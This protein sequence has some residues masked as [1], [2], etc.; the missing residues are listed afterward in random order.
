MARAAPLASGITMSAASAD[1]PAPASSARMVAPRAWACSSVSSTKTPA[2]SPSTRPRRPRLKGRQ[3][4]SAI[5]RMASQALTLPTVMQA[6]APPA[7]ATS[8][9]PVC[10]SISAWASAWLLDAQALATANTGPRRPNSSEIC[11]A[12]ALGIT[13][14]MA[15]GC[16][17]GLRSPYK[18][19]AIWSC[20][21]APPMPVPM[22]TAVRSASSAAKLRPDWATAWR[23]ETSA[24]CDTG[25]SSTSR[26]SSKCSLAT[27]A[28]ACAATGVLSVGSSSP[29]SGV[30]PAR[31][32]R[33]PA[34]VVVA[35]LP[36]AL[37]Q[38]M[39]VMTTRRM[40][41]GLW[42]FRRCRPW[43]PA[44]GPRPR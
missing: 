2:P 16:T 30:M 27:K 23:A 41:A 6:S 3:V 37:T 24:I 5:T 22:I 12:G 44:A 10:S 9:V 7:N 8:A 17:R 1:M 20:V 31:P 33:M 28:L 42:M 4:S 21:L 15:M 26:L 40:A 25:S 18:R 38:P 36:R 43:R 35:V 13:R 29:V 11:E 34:H 19:L 39:P 32:S 14:T